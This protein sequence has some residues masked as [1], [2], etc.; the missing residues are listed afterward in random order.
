MPTS[1][2][3]IEEDTLISGMSVLLQLTTLVKSSP[4]NTS[5]KIILGD[6]QKIHMKKNI[7]RIARKI[8]K[9]LLR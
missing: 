5:P 1:C 3:Y 9:C 6:N 4:S 2:S 8:L 7:A